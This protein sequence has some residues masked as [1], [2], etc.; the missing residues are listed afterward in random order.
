[1]RLPWPHFLFWIKVANLR[2][3]A[4]IYYLVPAAAVSSIGLSL[5]PMR[6]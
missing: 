6:A 3:F 4:K 2:R 5:L 1:M